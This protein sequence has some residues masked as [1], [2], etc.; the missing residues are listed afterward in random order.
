MNGGDDKETMKQTLCALP[1]RYAL[2][3]DS[4]GTRTQN[5]TAMNVVPSAFVANF[6]CPNRARCAMTALMISQLGQIGGA[7]NL[8]LRLECL[9]RNTFY[10]ADPVIGIQPPGGEFGDHVKDLI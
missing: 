2:V 9:Q 8:V 4:A 6:S 7:H 3:A 10:H 5:L 1:L